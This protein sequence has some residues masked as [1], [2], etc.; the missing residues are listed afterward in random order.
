MRDEMEH[1]YTTDGKVIHKSKN[2]E[3]NKKLEK[4]IGKKFK[5]Y[6][7]LWTDVHK[8]KIITDFPLF[9]QIQPN[10]ICNYKCPHCL[11]GQPALKK[12]YYDKGINFITFQRIVLE[13]E[14]HDCPSIS[15]QGWNEPLAIKDL[16]KY[17]KFASDHGFIDIMLNTNG[18]LLTK[19]RAKKLLDSGLTRIRFSLD[20]VT[21]ET[22]KKVRFSDE[23]DK[24]IE[25]I[26]N[27]IELR[28]LMGYKLPVIGVSFCK[29]SKN[30]HELDKFFDFWVDKVD[31]VTSQTFIPPIVDPIYNE[32]YPSGN[33]N[34]DAIPDQFSC[35]QPF[36]RVFIHHSQ[37]YPCCYY[38]DASLKIGDL[39]KDTIFKA[40][41]GKKA[42]DLRKILR[43]GQYR[44]NETCKKCVCTTFGQI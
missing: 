10:M 33:N 40:W 44:D 7:K 9:L 36:E 30:E 38:S 26:D 37:I 4:L 6:R 23:Y 18:S 16:E 24:V 3:I 32:F 39:N 25:N 11:M 12:K 1:Q 14:E 2:E 41:N 20:A 43:K 8:F 17:I 29:I 15:P 5:K 19:D 21:S 42:T 34:C 35:P 28:D 27:F 13:G 31:L 22:Y